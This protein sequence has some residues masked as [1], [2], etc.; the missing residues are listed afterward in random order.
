MTQTQSLRRSSDRKVAYG[1]TPSGKDVR[2]RNAFGL[3]AG[4]NY[5]CPGATDT[6]SAVCY[7]GKIENQYKAVFA[8]LN[9]NFDL[10]RNASVIGQFSLIDAMILEFVEEC[11][12]K[13]VEKAFRIHWDG[14]FFSVAYAMAWAA[15]ARKHSD[16]QFWV[17]TRS[18]VP[19]LNV[20]PFI[21]GIPNLAVYLSVDHDNE[22]FAADILAEYPDVMVSVLSDTM[23]N[24]AVITTELTGKPGAKCP[25]LIKAI[26]LISEKGGACAACGLCPFGKA[27][28]RFAH[29]KAGRK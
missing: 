12:R 18:F 4:K 27:P 2:V 6:C 19:A 14:D 22:Q 15:I 3:P 21:A 16:V 9:A 24:A 17:Y 13:N 7:A 25:E 20:I 26:P 11:D 29:T 5:S 10:L 1:V 23:E 28:I 8:M